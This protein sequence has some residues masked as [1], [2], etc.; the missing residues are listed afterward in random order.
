MKFYN[1]FSD[2]PL[3][4]IG[5]PTFN[6]PKELISCVENLL[7]QTY[8]NI[9]IIIVDNNSTNKEYSTIFNNHLFTDSRIKVYK[10]KTN[11][12]V[13]KN[14]QKVLSYAKGE[15]FCWVSND[16]WRSDKFIENLFNDIYS[17][18][19]GNIVFCKYREIEK[20]NL[21]KNHR[22]KKFNYF[23]L[24]S[25]Y[26]VLRLLAFYLMDQAD[27]K[28]N[29]F[30]SLMKL[31]DIKSCDLKKASINWSDISMD[32]NIVYQLLIKNKV[33]INENILACLTVNNKKE[34]ICKQK[35]K[36]LFLSIFNLIFEIKNE[37]EFFQKQ[38]KI[39][40]IKKIIL[41]S[42]L[43]PIKIILN[44]GSRIF[45]KLA[46]LNRKYSI[47]SRSKIESKTIEYIQTKEKEFNANK[48][49]LEQVTLVSVCTVEG[50]KGAMAMRH[51][52]TDIN[53]KEAL[54]F[55]THKPWNL[56]EQIKNINIKPFKDVGEWGKFIVFDLYKFIKTPYILLIHP[57]GF[58]VNP[59]LWQDDFLNF[60][61]IGA[62]WPN[63]KDNYSY[64]TSNNEIVKVGN[65]V[66]IRSRE[67]LM[68]P[69]KLN[70]KWEP[71]YGFYHEDGF[72][73]AMNRDILKANGMKFADEKIAYRFSIETKLSKFRTKKSFVFHKWNSYNRNYPKF[74][75]FG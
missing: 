11:I 41:Y 60:D 74:E 39:T 4:S 22:L 3:I 69:S 62:P 36:N 73:C 56:G 42:I 14:A 59:D 53:F 35:N 13:L 66:S 71:Y 1:N 29:L 47:T 48:L 37:S 64:R 30:Y 19:E 70:L 26:K 32:R 38:F 20:G 43:F 23:L 9:E 17:L 21:S 50:E 7:N 58:V 8:K 72:L 44:I 57:D 67:L 61:Y 54:L 5:L 55:S 31:K 27:G 15:Y 2:K 33:F 51:S 49:S 34:Y 52:M 45:N 65:S 25:K 6:R 12:G 24:R 75:Y 68:L 63:P 28:S 16:D 46:L 40:G 10:N 18:G